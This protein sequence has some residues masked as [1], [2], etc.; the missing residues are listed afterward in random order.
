MMNDVERKKFLKH[1]E[2]LISGDM[3][4]LVFAFIVYDK[5][6]PFIRNILENKN[7]LDALHYDSGERL[8]V[9]YLED[10]QEQADSDDHLIYL[11]ERPDN[12]TLQSSYSRILNLITRKPISTPWP[13]LVIY[14]VV[15]EDISDFMIVQIDEKSDAETFNQLDHYLKLV[16]Y[17]IKNVSKENFCNREEIFELVKKEFKNEK[18][19]ISIKKGIKF[20][21]DLIPFISLF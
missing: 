17:A 11:V 4:A 16:A 19:W 5:K 10:D 20:T 3:E 9:Y 2:K 18:A 1:L 6:A 7:Y 8:A 21:K 13:F 12:E 15:N 14:Q